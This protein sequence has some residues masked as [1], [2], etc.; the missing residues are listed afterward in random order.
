MDINRARHIAAE[1]GGKLLGFHTISMPVYQI[2]VDY[3]TFDDNPFFP[4]QR[5]LVQYVDAMS[6][7]EQKNVNVKY[8]S[9]MLG[10]DSN[11]VQ[12]EFDNLKNENDIYVDPQD[13]TYRISENA[14]N[15]YLS[16]G[17]RPKKRVTGSV[18]LDGKTF[19]FLPQEAY[20]PILDV[21]VYVYDFIQRQDNEPHKPIDLSRHDTP[22]VSRIEDELNRQKI[23]YQTLGLEHN[24]CSDFHVLQIE[25]KQVYP[26]YLVYV[27]FEA[28][29][30]Q[31]LPFIGDVQIHTPAMTDTN[32]FAFSINREGKMS[33]ND[34]YGSNEETK[35][36]FMTGADSHGAL[37]DL[38]CRR[39]GIEG[40]FDK[41][42]L[43]SGDNI[44]GFT[45][46]VTDYVLKMSENPQ[47]IISDCLTQGESDGQQAPYCAI[48]L[49]G[50]GSQGVFIMDIHQQIPV[51][52]EMSKI[53]RDCGDTSSL[54]EKLSSITP[55]WRKRL[56]D[57]D[58]YSTLENIDS[59]RYI[60][61][62]DE[63]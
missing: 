12:S 10:V 52:I 37:T 24:E 23:P 38:V 30:I 9:A 58:D 1:R 31:K 42:Y 7:G 56:L 6:D 49:D 51:Y 22:E 62:F 36:I 17:S 44:H 47:K 60:H 40:D 27:D 21:D 15:K 29:N 26:V 35:N 20:A 63:N 11:L 54:E 8:L 61:P 14:R 18:I 43:V 45:V 57:M 16:S 48:R 33:T 4:I 59:M 25:K 53:I 28:G 41:E 34:G 2:I 32:L 55:D 3:E 46:N 5:A 50:Y 39:Y 13:A 19:D